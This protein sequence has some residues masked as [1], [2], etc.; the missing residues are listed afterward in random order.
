MFNMIYVGFTG[1]RD[2]KK[3]NEHFINFQLSV[4]MEMM[5]NSNDGSFS[6]QLFWGLK[7]LCVVSE[8]EAEELRAVFSRRSGVGGMH[9]S[10]IQKTRRPQADCGLGW[11][12]F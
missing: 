1:H 5:R 10:S 6:N 9:S 12:W 7:S 4:L 2:K 3:K 8:E 11:L